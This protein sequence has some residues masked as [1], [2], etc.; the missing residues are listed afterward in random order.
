MK[1]YKCIKRFFATPLK[2]YIPIDAR[3]CR[4][5]NVAKLV[6]SDAPESDDLFTILFTGQEYD[7]P[8]QVTWISG[9]EPPPL[10]TDAEWM[11]LVAT[12]PEDD[13]GDVGGVTG[14]QGPQGP[15]SGGGGSQGFQGFQGPAGGGGGGTQG[16][17]GFQGDVGSAGG[18][19]VQGPQGNDGAGVQGV[20]GDDGAQGFQG[21]LSEGPQGPQGIQGDPGGAQGYQ[22]PEGPQGFQGAEG[23]GVQ[24]PQG[25]QGDSG[26]DGVQGDVGSDGA[27]GPQGDSGS[28]GAQGPQGFQGDAGSDGAQGDSG[29]DGVQGPQGF[30]GAGA[31]GLQGLQG[32]QGFQ[33]DLGTQGFQGADQTLYRYQ[34]E[35]TSGE[36]V[37]VL[38]D[39][40]G[41]TYSRSGN[42]GTFTIPAGTRI[43]SAMI[44]VP[45]SVQVAGQFI[46]DLGTND[47]GNTGNAD[48][49]QPIANAI[50]EDTGAVQA[51][52][53]TFGA[54]ASR[55]NLNNMNTGA[56][57]HVRLAF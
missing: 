42:V 31:A 14:L 46:V 57:T 38:A 55:Y 27:Q 29:D 25:L 24:G 51:V 4:W 45:S 44:R 36:E 26:S 1:V 22:G 43:I 39:G 8:E 50:R 41:I 7:D 21:P 30:Q 34:V 47:M 35:S 37:E 52:T 23:A 49:W 48:R 10:G 53:V 40:N 33:G 13:C 12:Y 2:R 9:V 3:I 6:V 19:G 32:P 15:G 28:D 56:T 54:T 5:E 11:E 18:D 20:Q 16:P 17:Q